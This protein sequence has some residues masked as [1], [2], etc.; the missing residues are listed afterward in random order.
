MG[1][2]KVDAGSSQYA[3]PMELKPFCYYCDRDFDSTKTLVQHQ[4]TKHFS[5]AECGLK[6]DTVTGLRVHMLNAYKKPMK[7]V[8]GAIA[9]RDNPDIV[10]HGME[11]VP[12][13]I[14]QERTR[15]AVAEQRIDRVE[16][17]PREGKSDRDGEKAQLSDTEEGLPSKPKRSADVPSERHPKPASKPLPP[18]P[19]AVQHEEKKQ[20]VSFVPEVPH[21]ISAPSLQL[22][23]IDV[24]T[25]LVASEEAVT[26][27]LSSR[28]EAEKP[29]AG[30]SAAVRRLL[31]GDASSEAERGGGHAKHLQGIAV[32][33]ALVGL[34]PV[35]LKVLAAA[36]QLTSP[37]L[38]RPPNNVPLLGGIPPLQLG[39]V[40]GSSLSVRSGLEPPEKRPRLGMAA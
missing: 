29:L 4:R 35:A 5:C 33:P 12:K 24:L 18:P 13:T 26:A 16:K 15:K 14:I 32:P 25:P 37:V 34:H 20:R 2:K 17:P 39:P 23:P 30:V 11:G 36:G 10:V 19:P 6:F 1:K 8:P 22:V 27:V 40:S 3:A 28:L 21:A 9:G 31:L 7:E 38:A